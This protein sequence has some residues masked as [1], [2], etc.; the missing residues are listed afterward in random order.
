MPYCAWEIEN[1]V[2]REPTP[3]DVREW[4]DDEDEGDDDE[5]GDDGEQPGDSRGKDVVRALHSL[6]EAVEALTKDGLEKRQTTAEEPLPT[7]FSGYC[8][9]TWGDALNSRGGQNQIRTALGCVFKEA[10]LPPNVEDAPDWC[11]AL[12]AAFE[13]LDHIRFNHRW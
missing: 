11:I 9:A 5:D 8:V 2:S 10:S 12:S 6:R 7:G 1:R 4:L 13:T 3:Q